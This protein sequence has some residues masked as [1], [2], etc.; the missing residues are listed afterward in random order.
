MKRPRLPNFLIVGAMKTGTTSLHAYL[1]TH[2]EIYMP[3]CKELD[4]FVSEKNWD[5]GGAWYERQ[6]AEA[7][8][9]ARALGEASTNYSKYPTF[10][11]VPERIR[12]VLP[13]VKLVYIVRDPLARLRSHVA[14]RMEEGGESLSMAEAAMDQHMRSCSNY[15]LQLQQYLRFFSRDQVLVVVSERLRVQ[16]EAALSEVF[17]F[18]DV[19]PDFVPPNLHMEVGQSRA[20]D[21]PVRL[22]GDGGSQ[23]RGEFAEEVRQLV[24]FMTAGFDG[25]GLLQ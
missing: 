17:S 16:R 7:P 25:W 14:H 4:Y 10:Q 20:L 8:E 2:P 1:R 13:Q 18:L 11:G 23:L 9:D 5:R 22:P 3:R 21:E 24:P 19:A 15:A 12:G 6:F